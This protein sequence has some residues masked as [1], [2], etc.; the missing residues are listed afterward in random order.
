MAC[1]RCGYCCENI[2][3]AYANDEQ[4]LEWIKARGFKIVDVSKT[5]IIVHVYH[6][7]INY[8]KIDGIGICKIQDI[9]PKACQT[10]PALLNFK[11]LTEQGIDLAKFIGEQCNFVKECLNLCDTCKE[12][13]AECNS[14][15][16]FGTGKGNDNVIKCSTYEAR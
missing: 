3:Y 2:V 10:Y 12:S 1:N 9:K 13:F 5:F 15:P 6:P 16:E 14:I 7:C 8:V 4:N 11:V